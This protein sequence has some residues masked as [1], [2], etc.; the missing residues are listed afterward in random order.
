M[1][2]D[3]AMRCLGRR[4]APLLV[5]TL[6][7]PASAWAQPSKR[8]LRDELPEAARRELDKARELYD[9][10]N[11]GP[12]ATE[13]M[14]V[15]E[16]SK[17]PRVLYNVAICE[18]N[19]S[20]FAKAVTLL[21]REIREGGRKLPAHEQRDAEVAIGLIRDF[22]S[23]VEVTSNE[24]GASI[25]VDGEPA[26]TTPLAKP[27]PVDVGK[28]TIEAKKTGFVTASQAVEVPR[29]H[30]PS[31]ALQLAPEQAVAAVTV[32]ASGAP[33]ANI[34]IDGVDHG[35]APFRGSLPLGR[36]TF[37]ARADGYAAVVQTTTLASA[38]PV[39]L[40]MVLTEARHEGKA[41]VVASPQGSAIEIDGRVVGESSW[42]GVLRSGGHHLTVKKAGFLDYSSELVVTDGQSRTLQIDLNQDSGRGVFFWAAGSVLVATGAVIAGVFLFRPRD[43]QPV[44]GTFDPGVVS[45]GWRVR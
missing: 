20:H 4:V 18:K 36:H 31:V 27:I 33:H 23:A 10:G 25:L 15:Y 19:L 5:T 39:S 17:N 21:E 3:G 26:G 7:A 41:K 40:A 44:V 43:P 34:W 12:A 38:A 30:T 22:V 29:R 35:P 14:V 2:Y 24:A 6:L 1:N 9:A 16:L 11:F 42:E 32:D 13:Y 37:E 8:S 28:H 45:T